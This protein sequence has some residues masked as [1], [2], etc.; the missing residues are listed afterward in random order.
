MKQLLSMVVAGAIALLCGCN[1][2]KSLEAPVPETEMPLTENLA[3]T[4]AGEYGSSPVKL[5][6]DFESQGNFLRVEGWILQ[7]DVYQQL[8]PLVGGA[9]S[10]GDEKFFAVMV[11]LGGMVKGGNYYESSTVFL[12]A[13]VFLFKI[14][15]EGKDLTIELV[16]F[17]DFD[18]NVFKPVD[19]GLKLA[20]H[21][22]VLNSPSELY[23]ML[24]KKKY[25]LLPFAE[26]RKE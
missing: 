3:G 26:L 21:G 17:A 11:D 12:I 9:F 14:K 23:R 15:P 25:K 7:D 10:V 13:P 24:E 22:L 20:N 4:Y 16:T 5:K 6:M 2:T 1:A 8:P 18:N 19:A